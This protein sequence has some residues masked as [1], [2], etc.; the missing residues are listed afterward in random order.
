MAANETEI[1]AN[2]LKT[3]LFGVSGGAIQIKKGAQYSPETDKGFVHNSVKAMQEY[4]KVRENGEDQDSPEKAVPSAGFENLNIKSFTKRPGLQFW[5][6][7]S[8]RYWWRLTLKDVSINKIFLSNLI[9]SAAILIKIILIA[10]GLL[11]MARM[12]LKWKA[13]PG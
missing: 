8:G 1:Q 10:T 3:Q 12:G 2:K 11:F 7:A 9:S 5:P 4:K 13:F 6:D